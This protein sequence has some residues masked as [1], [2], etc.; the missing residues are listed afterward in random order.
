[1]LIILMVSQ[2]SIETLH[3]GENTFPVRFLHSYHIFHVKQWGYVCLLSVKY[4][5]TQIEVVMDVHINK[6]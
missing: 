4:G 3:I 1:M 6:Y 2:L 5:I